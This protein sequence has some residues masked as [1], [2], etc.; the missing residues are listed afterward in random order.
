MVVLCGVLVYGDSIHG[1]VIESIQTP[2]IQYIVSTLITLHCVLTLTLL[3]NP[4]N[5][6]LEE[7][8]NIPHGEMLLLL[9]VVLLLGM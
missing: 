6:E 1:A 9:V 8:F 7:I 3:L 5:Q 2:W 4:L